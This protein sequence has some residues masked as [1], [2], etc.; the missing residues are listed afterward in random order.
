MDALQ[1]NTLSCSASSSGL[2]LF[3]KPFPSQSLLDTLLSRQ[4]MLGVFAI[5]ASFS[6]NEEP[7]Q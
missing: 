7:S 5:P 3:A 4:L 1:Q 6:A 2:G